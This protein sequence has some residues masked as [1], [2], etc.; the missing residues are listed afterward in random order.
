MAAAAR[1]LRSTWTSFNE[2]K[3][4]RLA[5]SIAY[6]TIFALAPLMVVV[7]AI[8]GALVGVENGGHGHHVVEQA[9]LDLVRQHAGASAATAIEQLVAQA[10]NKPRE[11]VIAQVAGWTMFVVGAS[12]LFGALQDALNA[13][14]HI[15]KTEA[16]WKQML[17]DRLTSFAMIVVIA[18]LLLVSFAANAGVAYVASRYLGDL[19]LVGNTATLAIV[20]GVVMFAI[21]AVVFALIFKVLPDAT[22][23]WRDVWIGAVA[24]S[25]LFLVGESLIALYLTLA[26]ITAGYGAAGSLLVLLIWIYYAAMILLLGAEFTKVQAGPVGTIAPATIGMTVQRPAGTDPRYPAAA[27]A[28]EE[29]EHFP[30]EGG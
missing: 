29:R 23:S 1:L 17:R 9:L 25:V 27:S 2:D 14:W 15:E 20:N 24:T 13:V 6:A 12:G 11:S 10:F 21:I 30:V 28:R 3:A 8:A 22:L 19:P 26:G 7:I 4:P 16:G 18:F 5:A